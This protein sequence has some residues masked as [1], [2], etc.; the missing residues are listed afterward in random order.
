MKSPDASSHHNHLVT[1]V[2]FD[3]GLLMGCGISSTCRIVFVVLGD[4]KAHYHN[5]MIKLR[6]ASGESNFALVCVVVIALLL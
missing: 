6:A 3:F 5:E 1:I 4:V 2:R